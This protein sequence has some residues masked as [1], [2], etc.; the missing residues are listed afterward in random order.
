MRFLMAIAV[1]LMA[2]AAVFALQNAQPVSVNF[3]KWSFEASLVIILFITFAAGALSA[4]LFSIPWRIKVLREL[5]GLK[6][7]QK[8]RAGQ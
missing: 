6:K 4:F 2:L 5:S 1:L 7:Q 3:L 8:D